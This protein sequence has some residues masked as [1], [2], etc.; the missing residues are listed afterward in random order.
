MATLFWKMKRQA[1]GTKFED[2]SRLSKCLK[3][4]DNIWGLITHLN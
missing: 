4:E 1:N 3:L 2:F